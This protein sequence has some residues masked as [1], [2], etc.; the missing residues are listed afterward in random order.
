[1]PDQNNKLYLY[2]ALELR[3]EYDARMKTLKD[4]LPETKQ[5]RNR[6]FF[7]RDEKSHQRPSSEF[8]VSNVRDQLKALEYKRRKLNSAVQQTNFQHEIE[9]DGDTITLNEALELRKGLNTQLGDLHT[10]VVDAAYERV[11][12]KEDRDIVEPNELSYSEC[13]QNLDR[14]R[15]SF[16]D[17]NRKLRAASFEVVVDF[18]DE[19]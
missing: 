12:Y 5:N 10:Q 15:V 8:N 1:M 17:L 16:R 18:Q 14:V 6:S 19:G 2:E 3:A 7:D 13:V 4:C 9:Y 11:I